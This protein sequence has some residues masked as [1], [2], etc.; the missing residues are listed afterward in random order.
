MIKYKSGAS[1]LSR[2]GMGTSDE[3]N[4]PITR[5]LSSN[6]VN[7]LWRGKI[8]QWVRARSVPS[9]GVPGRHQLPSS[10]CV[11]QVHVC[12]FADECIPALPALQ[13]YAKCWWAPSPTG[14]CSAEGQTNPSIR[15]TLDQMCVNVEG[16]IVKMVEISQDRTE[17]LIPVKM[18][19]MEHNRNIVHFLHLHSN[20]GTVYQ[21]TV[22]YRQDYWWIKYQYQ[23][24]KMKMEFLS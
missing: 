11:L 22:I 2:E 4:T 8:V 14:S 16:V 7:K 19:L 17:S 20:A 6:S 9:H 24:H 21:V 1:V 23:H 15:V 18:D 13:T 5:Y 3:K 10:T 12:S